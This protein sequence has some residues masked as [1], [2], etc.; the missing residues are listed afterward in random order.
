MFPLL[1]LPPSTAQPLTSHYQELT[2]LCWL[3]QVLTA[4]SKRCPGQQGMDAPPVLTAGVTEERTHPRYSL[5]A[6]LGFGRAQHSL[7]GPASASKAF[8]QW[9][10]EYK[11]VSV[12]KFSLA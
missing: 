4:L 10:E 2:E 7:S 12:G 9:D 11:G 6:F 5:G 3:R 1:W 8:P